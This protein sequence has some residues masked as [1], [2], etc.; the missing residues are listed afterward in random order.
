MG[1]SGSAHAVMPAWALLLYSSTPV[2]TVAWRSNRCHAVVDRKW[3]HANLACTLTNDCMSKVRVS[4][5]WCQRE[6]SSFQPLDWVRHVWDHSR[7]TW[8]AWIASA[9]LEIRKMNQPDSSFT[10]QSCAPVAL[11]SPWRETKWEE[12]KHLALSGLKSYLGTWNALLRVLKSTESFD[13]HTRV[14]GGPERS[15]FMVLKGQTLSKSAP[16]Q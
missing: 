11:N 3:C 7:V 4:V 1:Q 14:H 5:Y 6:V 15:V 8:I 9:R 16:T 10:Y 13:A 2:A 12:R